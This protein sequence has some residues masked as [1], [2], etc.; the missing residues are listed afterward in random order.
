MNELMDCCAACS[1]IRYRSCVLYQMLSTVKFSKVDSYITTSRGAKKNFQSVAIFVG[2]L[3]A[4]QVTVNLPLEPAGFTPSCEINVQ[5]VLLKRGPVCSRV[6]SE[7]EGCL[8]S[9]GIHATQ[10]NPSSRLPKN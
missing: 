3:Y 1:A 7:G 8:A 4:F 10:N 9:E 2:C 5:A 6:R